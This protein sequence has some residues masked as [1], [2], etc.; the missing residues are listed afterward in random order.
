MD[1]PEFYKTTSVQSQF[2]IAEKDFDADVLWF[3][4]RASDILKGIG[5]V[6]NKRRFK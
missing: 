1:D 5:F 6:V 2:T 3:L 4:Y